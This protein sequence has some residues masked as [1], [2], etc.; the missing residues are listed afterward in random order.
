MFQ[1]GTD[2]ESFGKDLRKKTGVA[3]QPHIIFV[4]GPNT[5]FVGLDSHLV[6]MP[7]QAK[8]SDAFDIL[9]KSFYVFNAQYPK[10]LCFFYDFMDHE[11]Y[12]VSKE[13]PYN[14]VTS[15][16]TNLK[17]FREKA[18]LASVSDSD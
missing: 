9:F 2:I 7:A 13:K 4:E 12:G 8:I 18:E 1:E 14:T 5:F 15:F 17:M 16:M 10:G 6:E 3:K 11:I